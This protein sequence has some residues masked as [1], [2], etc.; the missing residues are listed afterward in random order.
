[1]GEVLASTGEREVVEE[2][3]TNPGPRTR[4]SFTQR[5]CTIFIF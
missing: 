5:E 1:M 3:V 2:A 4:E